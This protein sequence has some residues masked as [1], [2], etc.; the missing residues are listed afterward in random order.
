MMSED[1]SDQI[2]QAVSEVVSQPK[3]E[4]CPYLWDISVDVQMQGQIT[5]LASRNHKISYSLSDNDT[6]AKIQLS[7]LQD[8]SSVPNK[9]FILLIRDSKI[10]QPIGY[11]TVNE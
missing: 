6:K 3:V 1:I 9:D 8:K 11:F 5:R 7:D 2:M 4:D 10:N